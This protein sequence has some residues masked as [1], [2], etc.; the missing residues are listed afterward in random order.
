V[1]S[2]SAI[3][4]TPS[5]QFSFLAAG[6][7]YLALAVSLLVRRHADPAWLLIAIA[8]VMT[9]AWAILHQLILRHTAND[10]GFLVQAETLRTAAWIA[11]PLL[12]Q[13][14]L[15]GLDRRPSSLFLVAAAIGF[16]VALQ[17]MLGATFELY[18]F[19]SPLNTQP[20][21]LLFIATRIV[22]AITGLVLLH[23]L[24]VNARDG[25]DHSF[26]LLAIGLGVIFAYDL[27]LYTLH[28]LLGLPNLPLARLRGAV[29]ALAVP[30]FYVA[31]AQRH[32]LGFRV[33]REAAFQ[34]ISFTI[35]GSYLI[36]MSLAA[37]ALRL[38]G[39]NWGE[40]LQILFLTAGLIGGAIVV[41]S[42]RA[43]ATLKVHIARNFYR[44]RYDYRTEWLRFIE[45]IDG[46]GDGPTPIRERLIRAMAT[47]LHCPGGALIEASADGRFEPTARW[48]WESLDLPP[49]LDL[50]GFATYLAESGR[51]ADFNALRSGRS[52]EIPCPAFAMADASIWLGVPLPRSGRLIGILLLEASLAPSDLNWEDFDLLRT[53]GRQGASYL[54]EA[55]TQLRLD[56]ARQFEEFNRRFAF[57]MHDLKNIVS[58]LGL[59]ARN[60]VR[61]AD[62][63][64]FQQDMVVTL[65]ISVTKMNDLMRLLSRQIDGSPG[66]AGTAPG[67]MVDLCRIAAD[68]VATARRAAPAIELTAP[69]GPLPVEGDRGR[70][71]AMLTHLVQNAVDASPPGGPVFVRLGA[72]DGEAVLEVEDHGHGMSPAFICNE[73]FKPFRSTKNDGFGIGAFEAREI[74]RAH[75]GRIEVRSLPGQ[76]SC[77]CVRLPL[78]V[79]Q[80]VS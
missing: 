23:N 10:I 22:V 63:P 7:A 77:F 19:S 46:H 43:R 15:W 31:L 18:T 4:L 39:G 50:D 1:H 32:R 45:T 34:T 54:A 21:L 24:Y 62:K 65:N 44:Y 60:A 11:V 73:L 26:R 69:P 72:A 38:S 66:H 36:L 6:A 58:Q 51:I 17:L 35:I 67:T 37:Y 70:L 9:S 3:M 47:V 55:E 57:V 48:R 75:R 78:L 29:N 16:V 33:S 14:R 28:F 13:Q 2:I 64:E 42:P 71:E 20:V 25:E 80:G 79:R 74:V 8:A 5:G 68:V 27:N 53:L 30:L 41:L 61:H 40:L 76:G 12:M 52:L 56:E 49:A 59:L